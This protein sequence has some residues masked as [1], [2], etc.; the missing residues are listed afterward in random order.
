M[1]KILFAS[2]LA[3]SILSCKQNESGNATVAENAVDDTDSS[4]KGS[5]ESGR[6]ENMIDKIYSEL[7]KKDK[8]LKE[9]DEKLVKLNE[10]NR[11]VLTT[12]EDI[13]YKSESFYQDAH[14]Q[15]TNVKD[16]LL[17]QQ[18]EKEI[19]ISSDSYNQKISKVKELIN[20]VNTN[21]DHITNLYTA[22]KIRKALPEIEKYQNA[23][24]MKTDNLESF[25]EKQNQLLSELKNIK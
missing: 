15:A 25:I 24:P 3:L 21:N 8:K 12:Y 4:L 6:N 11:K 17:K 1:K 18:L 16:S 2:A 23:H 20:K 5:F 22:F 19:K 14:F 10:E 7:I 9:L 13:L